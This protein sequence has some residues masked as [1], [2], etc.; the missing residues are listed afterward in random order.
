LN[1]LSCIR[2]LLILNIN[3][4]WNDYNASGD[5]IGIVSLLF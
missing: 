5:L 4:T 3:L 1:S 2:N